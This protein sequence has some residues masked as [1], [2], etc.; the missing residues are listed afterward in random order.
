MDYYCGI[1]PVRKTYSGHRKY[2]QRFNPTE[3]RLGATYGVQAGTG[4]SFEQRSR[5]ASALGTSVISLP[6]VRCYPQPPIGGECPIMIFYRASRKVVSPRVMG[7]ASKTVFFGLYG[8]VLIVQALRDDHF[9]A[10]SHVRWFPDLSRASLDDEPRASP[11]RNAGANTFWDS[12]SIP[13][14][15]QGAIKR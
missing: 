12:A 3:E 13:P 9:M 1:E 10:R 8:V 6:C 4:A 5:P 11:R 15:A 7:L 2:A 14:L